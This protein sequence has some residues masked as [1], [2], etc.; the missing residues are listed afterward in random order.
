MEATGLLN[1]GSEAALVAE[2]DGAPELLRPGI[3]CH[4]PEQMDMLHVL[5]F[6]TRPPLSCPP[7]CRQ[8]LDQICQVRVGLQQP[9]PGRDTVGDVEK[10]VGP[11]PM[12]VVE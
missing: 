10:L 7:R 4:E 8:L 6:P 9:P 11:E 5:R 1:E 12:K 2:A 3:A